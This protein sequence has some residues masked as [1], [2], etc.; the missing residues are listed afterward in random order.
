MYKGDIYKVGV[1]GGRAM[2]L[3]THP[4]YNFNPKWSPDGKWIAFNSNRNGNHDVFIMPAEGGVAKRLTTHSGNE[5]L[6]GFSPDGKDVYFTANIQHP[7]VYAQFPTGWATQ[8]YKISVEGGR[9][10]L[11]LPNAMD[12]VTI[13]SDGKFLVYEDIKGSENQWRKHQTSS[14]A[15]DVWRYDFATNTHISITSHT[16]DSRNP[17]LSK[18]GKTVYYLS[19]AVNNPFNIVKTVIDSIQSIAFEGVNIP[20]TLIPITHLTQSKRHPVRFLSI[21][22]EETLCYTYDGKLY[23]MPKNGQ[24]KQIKVDIFRDSENP[25]TTNFFTTGASEAKFSPNGKEVAVIVR[26]DVYVTSVEFGTTKRISNTPATERWLTWAPDGK[27]LA[28]A[29]ERDGKW[30]IMLAKNMATNEPYFFASNNIVEEYLVNDAKH[31]DFQPVFAPNGKEIAFIR[32]KTKLHAVDVQTKKVRQ[33]TDGSQSYSSSDGDQSFAWS[34]DSK[35]LVMTFMGAVRNPYHDIG[36]VSAQGGKITSLTHSGYIEG[37]PS[38][39]MNGNVILFT[40]DRFGMRSH[41][42]WGSQDDVFGIF[43]NQE[44]LDKF[45]M[46]KEEIELEKER[47]KLIGG[48]KDTTTK[49]PE[50]DMRNIENRTERL[51]IHSTNLGG[52]AMTP[53]GEKL[54]YLANVERGYDLWMRDFKNNTTQLVEKLNSQSGS[55]EIDAK[56]EKL[57]VVAGGTIFTLDVKNTKTRKNINYRAQVES[58]EYG[59]RTAMFDHVW[60]TVASRFYREDLHGVDWDGMKKD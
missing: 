27:S 43:A 33:I 7:A 39:A 20:N 24:P 37:R 55:L 46:T 16:F 14:V 17:V 9:P 30:N 52:F 1:D 60:R 47:Q 4:A 36:I 5:R 3:T 40:S 42:S 26:G 49:F 34:P 2:Q 45:K 11:V 31:E 38:F 18:D 51:T 21:S 15:R 59:A 56:G 41:G 23:V 48:K 29:T 19:E 58:D 44:A 28:Y 8:L 53:D 6:Q 10:F 25:I 50:L 35:W 32:D 22:G 57:M 13:S 12:N 54:F